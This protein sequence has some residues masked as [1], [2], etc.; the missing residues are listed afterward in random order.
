MAG[1]TEFV[2][3]AIPSSN[4]LHGEQDPSALLLDRVSLSILFQSSALW[5]LDD[6]SFEAVRDFSCC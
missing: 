4:Q 5:G 3:R 1:S 6:L 2:D